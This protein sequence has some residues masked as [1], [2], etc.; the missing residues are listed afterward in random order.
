MSPPLPR[1]IPLSLTEI[2]AITSKDLNN[3][4]L[5]TK[6]IPNAK[7]NILSLI[8]L[9]LP[10]RPLLNVINA[11]IAMPTKKEIKSNDI[12]SLLYT[13]NVFNYTNKKERLFSLSH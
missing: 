2:E 1:I 12:F 9:L 11:K 3:K 13:L 6:I 5:M 7:E 10:K 8:K 4:N